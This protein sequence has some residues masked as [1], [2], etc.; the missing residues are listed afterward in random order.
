M[1]WVYILK[2][3]DDHYYVGE[4]KN[5]YKRFW[6]HQT[7][8]G[9]LNTQ[10][11][12]VEEIIAIYKVCTISK[13]IAYNERINDILNNEA[14][15]STYSKGY[16]NPKYLLNNWNNIKDDEDY[17]DAEANI[18]ECMMIHRNDEWKKFRGGKY[19]RFDIEYKYPINECIKDLP[20][21]KC[22]LPCDI[23]KTKD[24]NYL[25]FRCPK[26]N[27][28]DELCD[29]WDIENKPCNFYKEYT[30][31]KIIKLEN[32]IEF[33]DR[34]QLLSKLFRKS[35]WLANI[36]NNSNNVNHK[37]IGG[38]NSNC[39]KITDIY[40]G[41]ELPLCFDCF[42]EKNDELSKKYSLNDT[43]LFND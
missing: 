25:Y 6:Q 30:K 16:W 2:C 36:R 26:K 34:K 28:W 4:T 1:R 21:C 39:K 41:D 38:C 33:N 19:T 22:G 43:C 7:G 42:I 5:L 32:E 9:S 3:D 27:L 17:L 15:K 24:T 8:N 29:E 18:V 23:N 37:C 14:I 20:L 35:D 12:G 31:D 10:I 13:F 40:S 11:Y